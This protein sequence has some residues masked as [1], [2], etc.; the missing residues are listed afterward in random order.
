M[1]RKRRIYDGFTFYNEFELLEWRLKMLYDVVDCFVIVEANRTFQNKQKPFNFEE[2]KERFAKYADK[3]RYI[4]IDEEIECKDNWSIEIYQRNCIEKGLVDCQPND[5]VMM[6]DIDE[7]PD[8]RV[9]EAIRKNSVP[10]HV[11]FP[12]GIVAE[13][14]GC[15]GLS[16]NGRCFIRSLPL[17]FKRGRILDFLEKSPVVSEQRMFEFFVNYE[18]HSHW[19]GTIL[20]LYKNIMEL[21]K[22]RRRRNQLPMI[23]NGWHFSSMGG[24]KAIQNK[25]N[26][27]S[28]GMGNPIFGLTDEAQKSVIAKALD[29]G[30]VWWTN[31]KLIIR[32]DVSLDIPF[33]D[34]L[35]AKYAF[36]VRNK[37]EFHN[38]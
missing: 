18:C 20:F 4:K 28:D 12:F 17:W 9:L 23:Q 19:C 30:C 27:T 33:L 1:T 8:P 2:Q 31:E 21:Q 16:R 13:R 7:F 32:D 24:I 29:S 38:K 14:S 36:M 15:R 37:K 6:G 5:I 22:L 35:S 25:F 26:A 3:I 10:I 11:F 34:W